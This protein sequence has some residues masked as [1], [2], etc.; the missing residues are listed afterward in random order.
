MQRIEKASQDHTSYK[1][2][3]T[4]EQK[5]SP[6]NDLF[7]VDI[8]GDS[9]N[10]KYDGPDKALIPTYRP[11]SQRRAIGYRATR[12]AP[13]R[14]LLS[15]LSRNDRARL[16]RKEWEVEPMSEAPD[17][18]DSEHDFVPLAAGTKRRCL[19]INAMGVRSKT[20]DGE[21]GSESEESIEDM[22][23]AGGPDN[24]S[25]QKDRDLSKVKGEN[26]RL[27]HLVHV[28]PT[29]AQAWQE[30]I[31]HQEDWLRV[32]HDSQGSKT[33]LSRAVA[34]LRSSLYTEAM[35]KLGKSHPAR[36]LFRL[37][38]LEEGEKVWEQAKLTAKWEDALLREGDSLRVSL[39]A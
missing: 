19:E 4:P 18:D 13:G 27:S 36:A 7:F 38:L 39:H 12:P 33:A 30:Y 26:A 2:S 25:Q 35:V 24:P 37:K 16:Q 32:S 8:K 21:T 1:R 22:A 28:Q 29:D 11:T 10:A 23:Q 9:G 15:A 14:S 17:F 31:D 6:G 5:S 34:D 20:L 3:R